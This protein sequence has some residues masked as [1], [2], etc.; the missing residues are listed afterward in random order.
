LFEGVLIPHF[1]RADRAD[2]QMLRRQTE[3]G[4][5]ILHHRTGGS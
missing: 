4:P 3:V 1:P 5:R 2:L